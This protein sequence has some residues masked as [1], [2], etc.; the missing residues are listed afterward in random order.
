M[1]TKSKFKDFLIKIQLPY[2]IINPRKYEGLLF[3]FFWWR[4]WNSS[5]EH[6]FFEH[7]T[8]MNPEK[9]NHLL[10]SWNSYL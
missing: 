10:L 9:E 3:L 6:L 7:K 4:W 5:F 1:L 2:K 8:V